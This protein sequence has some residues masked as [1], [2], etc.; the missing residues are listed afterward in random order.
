[1]FFFYLHFRSLI[2]HL[3]I[4]LKMIGCHLKK[5]K[6][7]VGNKRTANVSAAIE[8]CGMKPFAKRM[9]GGMRLTAKGWDIFEMPPQVSHADKT[10]PHSKHESNTKILAICLLGPCSL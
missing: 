9:L 10:S 5:M 6:C 4:K 7:D 2:N 3:G 8:S 1:M